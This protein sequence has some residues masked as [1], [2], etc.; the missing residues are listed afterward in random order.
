MQHGISALK[1]SGREYKVHAFL[2]DAAHVVPD[3]T[4]AIKT[5]EVQ[6]N[7]LDGRKGDAFDS[8]MSY[9]DHGDS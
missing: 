6:A 3:L 9:D 8:T 2:Q 1:A 5:L 4:D 7:R